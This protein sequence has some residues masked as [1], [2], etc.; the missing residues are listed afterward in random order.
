MLKSRCWGYGID[1]DTCDINSMN[2][3]KNIWKNFND[4]NVVS[5]N[6]R[7]PISSGVGVKEYKSGSGCEAAR[8]VL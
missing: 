3:S 5:E 7:I 4:R 1:A 2:V 8:S 6:I